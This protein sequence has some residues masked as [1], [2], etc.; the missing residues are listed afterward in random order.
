MAGIGEM[1]VAGGVAGE[2]TLVF[3]GIDTD[4]SLDYPW[5][6]LGAAHLVDVGGGQ[7]SMSVSTVYSLF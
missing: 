4:C 5:D 2:S 6:K 7:G 3:A 1:S